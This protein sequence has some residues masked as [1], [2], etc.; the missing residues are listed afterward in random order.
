[1]V[2]QALSLLRHLFSQVLYVPK[3]VLLD[4]QFKTT[5]GAIIKIREE[6]VEMN[7]STSFF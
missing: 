7:Y 2:R 1:M 3:S 5:I 4:I 6:E